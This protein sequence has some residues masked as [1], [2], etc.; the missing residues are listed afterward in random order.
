MKGKIPK[1]ILVI[2]LVWLSLFHIVF[3]APKDTLVPWELQQEAMRWQIL[4]VEEKI[5]F[6]EMWLVCERDV[7]PQDLARLKEAGYVIK[8][9][10]DN[11]VLVA[12]PITLY[13]HVEKGVDNFGFVTM[14]LP[15]TQT[16]TNVF[17]LSPIFWGFIDLFEGRETVLES[18]GP[19]ECVNLFDADPLWRCCPGIPW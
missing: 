15:P 4:G 12:A 9:V 11:L 10:V 19:R 2:T 16:M 8:A 17:E 13:V 18:L 3:G 5:P 7:H 1:V 6:R 14:L